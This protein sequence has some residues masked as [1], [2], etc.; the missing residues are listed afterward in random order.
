M[1]L[2][3]KIMSPSPLEQCCHHQSNAWVFTNDQGT[4]HC[5]GEWGV[6]NSFSFSRL[7][8]KV[9]KI[10]YCPGGYWPGLSEKYAFIKTELFCLKKRLTLKISNE[11]LICLF[12][13]VIL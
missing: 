1:P 13:G 8:T 4:Q 10:G 5:Q 6:E 3:F 11:N 12:N 2:M 7:I 9:D